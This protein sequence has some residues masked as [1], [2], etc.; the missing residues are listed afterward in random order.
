M[1]QAMSFREMQFAPRTSNFIGLG[2]AAELGIG[3][4][5]C[6]NHLR[7]V[8]NV[9]RRR[10]TRHTLWEDSR[11]E[12]STLSSPDFTTGPTSTRLMSS[13]I[14]LHCSGLHMMEQWPFM[15]HLLLQYFLFTQELEPHIKHWLP[16]THLTLE[17]CQQKVHTWHLQLLCTLK[18]CCAYLFWANRARMCLSYVVKVWNIFFMSLTKFIFHLNKLK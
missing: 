10:L 18:C 16:W 7:I 1:V 4:F 3:F 15:C 14:S 2:T 5:G 17:L 11:M 8:G 6:R 12:N 13:V 9:S